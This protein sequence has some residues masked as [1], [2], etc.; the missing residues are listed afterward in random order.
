MHERS[1]HIDPRPRLPVPPPPHRRPSLLAPRHSAEPP[2][3]VATPHPHGA[4]VIFQLYEHRRRAPFALEDAI[5]L[6]KR[7]QSDLID[8][9]IAE[10]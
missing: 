7:R 8:D 5:A 10:K 1:I 2:A 4:P 9:W 6:M 3:Q